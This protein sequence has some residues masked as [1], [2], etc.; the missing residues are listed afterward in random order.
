MSPSASTAPLAAQVT[1]D[2]TVTFVGDKVAARTVGV[3]LAIVTTFERPDSVL[4][5]V[6]SFAITA[7][8]RVSLLPKAAE[9]KVSPFVDTYLVD[10][11]V[12]ASL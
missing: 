5:V 12:L 2:P 8:D 9:V 11:P 4:E 3:V 6:P 1:V 7:Q 10:L